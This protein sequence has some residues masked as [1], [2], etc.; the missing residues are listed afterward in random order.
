MPSCNSYRA[1]LRGILL[2]LLTDNRLSLCP[3]SSP[4]IQAL[5]STEY[6]KQ[7]GPYVIKVYSIRWRIFNDWAT[8]ALSKVNDL[9]AC[10]SCCCYNFTVY[11]M[12]GVTRIRSVCIT[13]CSIRRN[14]CERRG[15]LIRTYAPLIR[16]I[17]NLYKAGT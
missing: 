9:R 4:L 1:L 6:L 10:C 12:I 2:S 3:L 14:I 13:F 15:S 8:G 11:R 7:N 5:P 17:C 16:I